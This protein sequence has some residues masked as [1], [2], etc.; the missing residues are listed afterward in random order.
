MKA[1]QFTQVNTTLSVRESQLLTEAQFMQLLQAKDQDTLVT[2]LQSTPFALDHEQLT[3]PDIIEDT[4][5]SNLMSEYQFVLEETP[6]KEVVDIFL[7]K[8][9]YH[10]LKVLLK[11]KARDLDLTHL[12]I[13]PY[14]EMKSDLEYIVATFE[15]DKYPDILVNSV[16]ATWEDYLTYEDIEA[17]EVGLDSAYFEH[18]ESLKSHIQDDI[19]KQ[20]ITI[21]HDFYNIITVKRAFKANRS[22]SFMYQMM[23]GF[24]TKTGKQFIQIVENNE[25]HQWFDELN[26]L[27][28]D[29]QFDEYSQKMKDNTITIVELETLKDLLIHAVVETGQFETEGPLALLRY[30]HGKEMEAVNMRLI[31]TGRANK[32]SESHI[33]ERMKPIYGK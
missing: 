14:D 4:I 16:R 19:A 3:D 5:M 8:Y 6:H 2:Y 28:F 25:L 10:N 31:L 15:S 20:V 1:G 12:L 33:T 18:L 27:V 32:L 22:R 29:H 26:P 9:V 17:I 13:L 30:L 24:G 21:K 23:S 7:L 11:M